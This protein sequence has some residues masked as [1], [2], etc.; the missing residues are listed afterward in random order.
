MLSSGEK[1]ILDLA[2]RLSEVTRMSGWK[3]MEAILSDIGQKHYPDPTKK[4][5]DMFP[6]ENIEKDYTFARGAT[7][8][9]K[10][11]MAV[12]LQQKDI[13]KGLQEKADEKDGSYRIGE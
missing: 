8:A 10:E 5:Y 1:D 12:M 9:V 11:F 13:A 3:D 7:E 4:K 6:W 2:Y